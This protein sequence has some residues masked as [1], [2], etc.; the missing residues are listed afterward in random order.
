M[1]K[2]PKKQLVTIHGINTEGLWQEEITAVLS[3]HF[4]CVPYKYRSYR[5]LGF[6]RQLVG[7]YSLLIMVFG[8][9]FWAIGI[10]GGYSIWLPLILCILCA[11]G[12]FEARWGRDKAIKGFR[13]MLDEHV[14]FTG[15]P[16]LIAH[17]FGT[18]L[19]GGILRRYAT[20]DFDC[21]ILTGSVLPRNFPWNKLTDRFSQV[22]NE[23]GTRDLVVFWAGIFGWI[24]GIRGTGFGA[25]G[26]KGFKTSS[27]SVDLL[28]HLESI[29]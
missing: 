22:R 15:K 4:K 24:G 14:N 20:T 9:L 29:T 1:A 7:L 2:T 10:L 23:V 12:I 5:W 26:R 19:T 8:L 3:P 16:H 25:A 11:F 17:S 6:I 13:K 21:I 18:Y 27:S 28:R